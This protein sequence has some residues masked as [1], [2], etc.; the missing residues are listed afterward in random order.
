LQFQPGLLGT[1]GQRPFHLG[2]LRAGRLRLLPLAQGR[3]VGQQQQMLQLRRPTEQQREHQQA[4][5]SQQ[6]TGQDQQRLGQH[7][8][9]C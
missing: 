5:H 2:Q 8:R 9:Q 6:P 3:L 1:D 7:C 4:Q